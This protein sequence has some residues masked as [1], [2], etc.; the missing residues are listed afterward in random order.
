M[1]VGREFVLCTAQ[2]QQGTV[3]LLKGHTQ[4]AKKKKKD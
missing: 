4:T 1:Y 2:D 3:Y